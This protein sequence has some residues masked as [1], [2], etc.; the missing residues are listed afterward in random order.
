MM[1][2]ELTMDQMENV[3]GGMYHGYA[4]S[5]GSGM[6]AGMAPHNPNGVMGPGLGNA[7]AYI[8]P[9]PQ[10]P[11]IELQRIEAEREA[12]LGAPSLSKL[13]GY[14]YNLNC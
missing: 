13:Y 1:N 2:R 6:I 5:G 14:N 7:P 8:G 11:M 3:T 4:R 12:R 10:N 9:Q